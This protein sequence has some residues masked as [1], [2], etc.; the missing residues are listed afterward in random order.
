MRPSALPFTTFVELLFI[1]VFLSVSGVQKRKKKWF[2]ESTKSYQ[3][4]TMSH[5]VM[6]TVYFARPQLNCAYL[7]L[8][9][10]N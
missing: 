5:V 10:C 3:K 2:P 1:A 8:K 9:S 7:K 6:R 4:I